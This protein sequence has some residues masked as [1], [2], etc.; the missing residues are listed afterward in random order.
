MGWQAEGVSA[1]TGPVRASDVCCCAA[2]SSYYTDPRMANR[3]TPHRQA[4]LALSCGWLPGPQEP[5]QAGAWAQHYE[6]VTGTG[7]AQIAATAQKVDRG[8]DCG[9]CIDVVD[10]EL[11]ALAAAL[12]GQRR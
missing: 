5:G 2:S 7:R 12:L 1:N 3:R 11:H 9:D 10:H 8:P 6:F 4:A